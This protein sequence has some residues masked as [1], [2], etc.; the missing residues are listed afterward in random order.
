MT[1]EE[2]MDW[3]MPKWKLCPSIRREIWRKLWNDGANNKAE[4]R[5]ELLLDALEFIDGMTLQ[6]A[7]LRMAIEKEKADA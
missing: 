1:F 4:R 5:L 2:W 7:E 3:I 6:E